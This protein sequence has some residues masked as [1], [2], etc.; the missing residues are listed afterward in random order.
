MQFDI[1]AASEYI[2]TGFIIEIQTTVD[3]AELMENS[4]WYELDTGDIQLDHRFIHH[5][6]EIFKNWS[7]TTL[8]NIG[9]VESQQSV[10]TEY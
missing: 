10:V 1:V 8:K 6:L 4:M 9:L 3:T 7:L 2:M 5:R